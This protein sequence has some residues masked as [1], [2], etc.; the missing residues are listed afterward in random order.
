MKAHT[1][2][3]ALSLVFGSTTAVLAADGDGPGVTVGSEVTAASRYIWRGFEEG[4]FSVQPNTWIAFEGF[5]ATTWLNFA[6]VPTERPTVTERHVAVEYGRAIAGYEVNAGW[7]G[8]YFPGG[9]RQSHEAFLS[10]AHIGRLMPSAAVYHD[11]VLGSGTYLQAAVAQ[12]LPELVPTLDLVP[13]FSLGYNHEHWVEG[14]GLSDANLGL[15]ATWRHRH[16]A[17]SPFINH[18]HSLNQSIVPTRTY[19]GVEVA[20]R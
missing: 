11:F 18:S 1:A 7:R 12:R 20:L 2:A 8:Y 5:R 17:I 16:L 19:G 14:S 4:G 13:S 10:I 9:Y 6:A 3:F 15:K